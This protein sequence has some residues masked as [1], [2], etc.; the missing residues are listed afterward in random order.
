MNS[1]AIS[2]LM[3]A[4]NGGRDAVEAIASLQ[5]E[6]HLVESIFI[7]D[8]ASTD[9]SR[10]ILRSQSAQLGFTCIEP[11]ANEGFAGGFN[12]LF[13]VA[14][15]NSKAEYFLVLNNDTEAEAGFLRELLLRAE[16][17]KIVSPMILWHKDKSTVI[18]CAGDFDAEMIKMN[19]HFAGLQKSNVSPEPKFVEQTDGCCF[20][21]HRQ[22]L[23]NG[24]R[25]DPGL[26][27]YFEDVDFFMGLKKSG[28][29]FEYVPKSVLYHKEYGSSGGREKPS[30]FRNYYFYRNRM[31]ICQRLHSWP[32]RWLVFWR[33]IR[34][35]L[36]K[37]KEISLEHPKAAEAITQGLKDFFL[38]RMGRRY[39]P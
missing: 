36:Q 33:L 12:A 31:V 26:F 34:L 4:Y 1:A 6:R 21:I 10:E 2:I 37:K 30:A 29:S 13:K 3:L 20:L 14:L 5:P 16:P 19:N 38:S 32:K 15:E 8:N 9:G 35:A 11:S 25:F 17:H 7:S 27:I 39:I 22:W 23:E 18:Q 24:H 28:V